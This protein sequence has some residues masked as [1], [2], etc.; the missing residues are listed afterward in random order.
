MSRVDHWADVRNRQLTAASDHM[1]ADTR[2]DEFINELKRQVAAREKT[3]KELCD[4]ISAFQ[5]PSGAFAGRKL[6]IAVAKAHRISFSDL[7]SHK[8]EAPLVRARHHAMWEIRQHT[9]LSM[10]A[11]GRI[12]GNRDHT[13]ILYGIRQHERRMLGERE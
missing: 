6:A 4:E 9:K 3:I 11:I 12:L 2:T 5:V 10:P 1:R 13:T 7:V 8:R